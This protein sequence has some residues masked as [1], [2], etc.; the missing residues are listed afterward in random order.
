MP[1]LPTSPALLSGHLYAHHPPALSCPPLRLTRHRQEGVRQMCLCL[2][3]FMPPPSLPPLCMCSVSDLPAI[4]HGVSSCS[5]GSFQISLRRY[6]RAP[7]R[8]FLQQM[9][10]TQS[11]DFFFSMCV[12]QVIKTW[13]PQV[14]TRASQASGWLLRSRRIRAKRLQG[15]GAIESMFSRK[16]NRKFIHSLILHAHIFIMT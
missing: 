4:A 1:T 11:Q 8:K 5:C 13:R 9:K 3:I 10:E 16:I 2:T 15:Q 7:V 12:H 14:E 6:F